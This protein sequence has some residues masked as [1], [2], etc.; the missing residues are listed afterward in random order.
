MVEVGALTIQ[1][2]SG[3]SDTFSDANISSTTLGDSWIK[4]R[5]LIAG[6]GQEGWGLSGSLMVVLPTGSV[7][8]LSS[9]GAPQVMPMLVNSYRYKDLTTTFNLGALIRTESKEFRGLPLDNEMVHGLGLKYQATSWMTPGIEIIGRTDFS[10]EDANQ[11]TELVIGSNFNL[12]ERLYIDAGAGV[13]L[14]SGYGT[15]AVRAFGGLTWKPTSEGIKD[16][17]KDGFIDP[18]DQCPLKPEDKDQF[19]DQDGCPDPDNDQDQ[20]LDV[21]DQCPLEPEDKDQFEDE[22]GCPDPDNDQDQILDAVDQ[23]PMK[24]EDKDQFE[25]EDGCPDPDN[26]QDGI[27]DQAD[28][29][30]MQPEDKDQFEDENGCPDPDNDQ[31][32]VL[33]QADQCPVKKEDGNG[34]NPKDGCPLICRIAV[35]SQVLFDVNSYA[36]KSDGEILKVAD[37]LRSLKSF[38]SVTIEGHTDSQG[39]KRLNKSLSL[40]RAKS[41]RSILLRKGKLPKGTRLKP[42][43]L[44]ADK[45]VASNDTPE[46]RAKNR[47]VEFRIV[48]GECK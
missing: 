45:P 20:V 35:S 24:P 16:T 9:D 48:G 34:S 39:S 33:D 12:W 14:I 8:A 13:G 29:C 26:D 10:G 36:L 41:V 15:P 27:L 18:E 47:R 23:C 3:D 42:L 38:D 2:Q 44:A 6:S 19:E 32:G 30:P 22:D 40:M 21:D 25:D 37:Y 4:V 5:G 11:P 46:G 28:Q 1:N 7:D 43:G 31:D 17:D